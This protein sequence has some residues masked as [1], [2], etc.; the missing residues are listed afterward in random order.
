MCGSALCAFHL[1]PFF[2]HSRNGPFTRGFRAVDCRRSGALRAQ[3]ACSPSS[4][5]PTKELRV[6]I[7]KKSLRRLSANPRRCSIDLILVPDT[8]RESAKVPVLDGILVLLRDKQTQRERHFAGATYN[9]Q[10]R[11]GHHV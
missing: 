4:S 7:E 11:A 8:G 10:D 5:S 6:S 2:R 3:K 9:V 1:A